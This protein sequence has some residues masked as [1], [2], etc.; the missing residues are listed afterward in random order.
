MIEDAT[1]EVC[2][3]EIATELNMT[4]GFCAEAIQDT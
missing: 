3:G 2:A 4:V 1:A